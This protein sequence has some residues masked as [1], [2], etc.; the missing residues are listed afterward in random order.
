MDV[1]SKHC[2]LS[3]HRSKSS[4]CLHNREFLVTWSL[5][6]LF[7]NFTIFKDANSS[8]LDLLLKCLKKLCQRNYYLLI[9][10][11]VQYSPS[12][13]IHHREFQQNEDIEHN[14]RGHNIDFW[15]PFDV[16]YEFLSQLFNLPRHKLLSAGFDKTSLL[17]RASALNR[18]LLCEPG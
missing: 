1:K 7:K 8:L 16:R 17:K 6:L 18:T 5:I 9:P 14:N 10:I 2:C 13:L 15:C 12:H 3:F 4:V 11:R